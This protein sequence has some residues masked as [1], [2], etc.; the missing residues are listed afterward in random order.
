MAPVNWGN[1]AIARENS[2][3]LAWP[4][5]EMWRAAALNKRVRRGT[6]ITSNGCES[7]RMNRC[8][9]WEVAMFEKKSQLSRGR[10][11]PL[12]LLR[13]MTSSG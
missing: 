2:A 9:R 13:Q 3:R 8:A 12:N 11:E 6:T 7:V 4:H 5:A 10:Q 1:L